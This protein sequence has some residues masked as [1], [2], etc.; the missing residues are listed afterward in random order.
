VIRIWFLNGILHSPFRAGCSMMEL[1]EA[2]A[3][4]GQYHQSRDR[5]AG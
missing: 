1:S 5:R 3:G 2:E 4:P